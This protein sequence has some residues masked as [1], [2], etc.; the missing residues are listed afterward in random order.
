M[1]LLANGTEDGNRGN[2]HHL[3]AAT[4]CL[5]RRGSFRTGGLPLPLG[6]K[7]TTNAFGHNFHERNRPDALADVMSSDP[8]CGSFQPVY[9]RLA[10]AL[11]RNEPSGGFPPVKSRSAK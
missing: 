4:A 6:L 11:T 10:L 7:K 2:G 8:R 5:G 9:R 3:Q 1:I